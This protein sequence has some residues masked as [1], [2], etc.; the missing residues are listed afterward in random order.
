LDAEPLHALFTDP[1]VRR[2]LLDDQLV[3][4]AW[5]EEEI[6]QSEARFATGGCGLWTVREPR[7]RP[8]IGFAGFRFFWEPP[9]LELVYG[10]H[11]SRWGRG[12]A[13]EAARAATTYAFGT[14]GLQEVRA[15]TDEPNTASVAVLRRLGFEE[16]KR[17]DDGPAGTLRFRL[18]SER[19]RA[20][21][22]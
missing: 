1:G 6:T 16:W 17:T 21:R 20:G 11:P 15:A 3:S 13:T 7:R 8:I 4:L 14:L 18:S 2:W 5:V 9:E 19:W 22:R 12:L 10:L